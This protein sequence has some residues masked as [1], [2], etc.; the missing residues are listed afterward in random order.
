MP[1][2][3][4]PLFCFLSLLAG[5]GL[6]AKEKMTYDD[7]LLEDGT[8]L[9][10]VVVLKVEPDGLRLEHKNGVSKVKYEE[11]PEMV[12]KQF[13]FDRDKATEF[14]VAQETAR[15]NKAAEERKARVEQILQQRRDEQDTDLQR[16]R[17]AFYK[18]VEADEYS[19]PQ[20]DKTLM[21]SISIFTEAGRKDLATILE[22]DR[23]L[24]REKELVRPGEK[25]RREREQLQERIRVLENQV[26]GQI[27]NP[28][29]SV[30]ETE[31]VPFWIDRPVIIDRPVA[32]DPICP[33]GRPRVGPGSSVTRPGN[34]VHPAVPA[35]SAPAQP[36]YTPPS[37]PRSSLPVTPSRPSTPVNLPS[38]GAQVQGSHLWKNQRN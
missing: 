21:D 23:K 17:E 1:M 3:T 5:T 14:R 6:T 10:N 15:E 13:T 9:K 26:A 12:Q 33:P 24:L 11:L 7:L 16:A 37:P 4:L 36:A 19:Y 30:V 18:V 22:E 27:N 31:W 28:P 29:V 35:P 2:K 25:Y 8:T 32:V 34:V 20:L 38:S